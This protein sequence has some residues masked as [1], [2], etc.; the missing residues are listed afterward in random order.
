VAELPARD[1][2]DE[3]QQQALPHL[4][5][6]YNLALRL[7]GNQAE[8]EDLV[9]ETYL[10]AYRFFDTFTPGT[11]IKAWLF[12]I[13]R[14]TF[15]NRYR[16]KKVRPEEVEL[17][18]LEGGY[19]TA[20]DQSFLRE[21]QPRSPE[22]ILFHGVLDEEVVKALDALPEEY[23]TVVH[24]ALVE[25]LS[26]KEIAAVLSIP[27]G[28]VM[29][30]LHRGRRILQA[31]LLDYVKKKGILPASGGVSKEGNEGP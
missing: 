5:S 8:A 9:Q 7:T 25:E 2:R 14:N 21:H 23:R 20:V 3:F 31:A 28:T 12:R 22:E 19:E 24:L 16:A 6:L 11:Q 30:R 13:L 15:I 17:T 27:I 4:S 26:Y 18:R 29:S 10:R 1:R